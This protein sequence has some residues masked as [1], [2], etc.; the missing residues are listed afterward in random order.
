MRER[1]RTL[2]QQVGRMANSGLQHLGLRLTRVQ[3]A[4]DKRRALLMARRNI[5]LVV[6]VGANAGQYALHLRKAGFRGLIHSYEPLPEAFK[7]LSSRCRR[8]PAWRAFQLAVTEHG[9][10]VKLRVSENDEASSILE[11]GRRL[12][13]GREFHIVSTIEVGSTTLDAILEA[14]PRCPTMLKI[15]T[16]GYEDRVL[17]GGARRLGTVELLE[18]ELSLFEVY[19]G[20]KLWREMDAV[21]LAA[22][23]ELASLVEGF[24]DER[25]GELLQ[26]DAIYQRPR[27]LPG[28]ERTP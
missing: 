13:G 18:I 14:A 1:E 20:Q 15:D 12:E 6:D 17:A 3:S 5:G 26:V 11:M 19:R 25:T 21:L 27:A 24:Q 22:G 16:Q 28:A 7:E 8:D 10:P 4:A 2:V 9:E 23:F